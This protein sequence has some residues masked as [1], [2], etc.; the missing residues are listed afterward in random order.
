M[1]EVQHL[2]AGGAAG[3]PSLVALLSDPSWV[4]RRAVVAALA[5]VGTPAVGALCEVLRVDRANETRLAAAVDALVASGGEVEPAVLALAGQAQ[6]P[7]VICDVAQV[8]GRRKSQGAVAEL[9]RWSAHADDNVAVAALEALGRI[10]G[11]ASMEPLLQAVRTRNFFRTFPAIAVLGQ[12]GD[13]RVVVPLVELLTEPH[14]AA[15]AAAA[16]GRTAQLTAVAPLAR[17]LGTGDDELVRVAA[18]ALTDLRQRNIARFGDPAA[19]AAAFQA[20]TRE[21]AIAPR[22]TQAVKGADLTDTVALAS[23]LGWLHDEAGVQALLALLDG[24]TAVTEQAS[25]A[26]RSLAIE[27]EPAIR[28]ALRTG[29]SARRQ[30]LLPLLGA[31]R[32]I[33]GELTLCLD[34]SDPAVRA[35]ACDA[36][37]RIG[38]TSAVAQVFSLVGDADARVA[39]SALAAV[40]CLGSDEARR[41]ALAAARSPD[42]RMRRA[43]L[44]IVSYFGY[45]EGLDVLLEAATDDDERIREAATAGLALLDDPRALAALVKAALHPSGPTRAA[46]MRALAQAAKTPEVLQALGSGLADEDAWVRYYACQ[47]LGKLNVTSATGKIE[48]LLE[49]PAGQVRVAAIEAIARLGGDRAL[50]V[51]ERASQASDPDVRRAAL[52]GLGRLRRPGAFALLLRAFDSDDAVTRLAAIAAIADSAFGDDAVRALARAGADPDERVR[53]AA[54]SLLAIRPDVSASRWLIERLAV[55]GDRD[56]AVTALAQQVDGRVETILSALE[57][58]DRTTSTSLVEALLRMRRPAG[59]AAAAAALQ[60]ENVYARRAAAAAL[61]NVDTPAVKDALAQGATLDPDPEVRRICAAAG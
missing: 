44:R 22:L 26:L 13:P 18:R 24:D 14:Y 32:G 42:L 36:L 52:A 25:S 57:T 34:D 31:R 20:A 10:G 50:A 28:A 58:S 23:V 35:L 59:N 40:Q 41:Q 38:D 55:D 8:L 47:S 1:E 29:D 43:A 7:A 27:A 39:Q 51:L 54:F 2:A 16:L 5:R 61:A 30:R 45:P 60:M 4:V 56:R 3:V 33:V 46:T 9:A 11:A 12:S 6:N 17:L 37:G 19:A 49:D 53:A 21:T 15:E 48:G